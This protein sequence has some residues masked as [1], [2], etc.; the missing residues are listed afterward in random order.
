[1][2]NSTLGM[3]ILTFIAVFGAIS[4]FC[5]FFRARPDKTVGAAE[6]CES[7]VSDSVGSQLS[8]APTQRSHQSVR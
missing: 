8:A 7:G 4:F 2:N 5:E 6:G 3:L 1:M